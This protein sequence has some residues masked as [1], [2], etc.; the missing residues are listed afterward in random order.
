MTQ[1][2]VACTLTSKIR[3]TTPRTEQDSKTDVGDMAS[4]PNLT[5]N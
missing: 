1:P 4:V 2:T 3:V 5:D